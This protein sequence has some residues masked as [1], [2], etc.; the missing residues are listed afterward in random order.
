MERIYKELD[1]SLK[2]VFDVTSRI[3]E[4]MKIL[5]ESNSESKER[6]EKLA[7]QQ[8][9]LS[10]R[11]TIL[12]SSNNSRILSVVENEVKNL[13]NQADQFGT[14]LTHVEKDIAKYTNHWNTIFEFV[15][16]IGVM[17]VG[18]IILWKLGVKP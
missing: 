13:D 3:D 5:I 1:D 7:E 17:I 4:R 18:G 14:R 16:K 6:I 9:H 10:N 11:I 12:E 15:F 2:M 8:N